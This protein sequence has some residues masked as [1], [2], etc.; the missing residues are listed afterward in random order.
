M[1]PYSPKLI[2]LYC[3][4]NDISEGETPQM[5]FRSF[6]QLVHLIE[7]RLPNADIVYLPMKPSVNRWNL[8]PQYQEGNVLISDYINIPIQTHLFE[9]PIEKS[10]LE[11]SG[12]VKTD[13]FIADNLHMNAKGYEG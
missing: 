13:I 11:A 2:V 3:G 6:K 4:E 8:W 7:S 5:V 10:M 1:F 9:I 12:E